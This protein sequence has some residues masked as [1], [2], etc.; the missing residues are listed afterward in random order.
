MI[1]GT[2]HRCH[3]T[4]P[5]SPE[6]SL[7]KPCFLLHVFRPLLSRRDD[8]IRELGEVEHA[9]VKA[10]EEVD[11]KAEFFSPTWL[12]TC[13][14]FRSLS[15]LEAIEHRAKAS[16]YGHYLTREFNGKPIITPWT[17]KDPRPRSAHREQGTVE[18]EYV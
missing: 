13:G 4:G 14:A 2:C 16:E 6:E 1:E 10:V 12:C 8:L 3:T 17:R 18:E 9:L 5:V 11:D 7:C 15:Y